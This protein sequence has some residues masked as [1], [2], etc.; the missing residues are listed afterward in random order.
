MPH[1]TSTPTGLLLL[2][3]HGLL[4]QEP[5]IERV[6]RSLF[7]G[8][9]YVV[10]ARRLIGPGALVNRLSL[11]LDVVLVL[12]AAGTGGLDLELTG[13]LALDAVGESLH[14]AD[15]IVLDSVRGMLHPGPV[16]RAQRGPDGYIDVAALFDWARASSGASATPPLPSGLRVARRLL[17]LP[18]VEDP[19]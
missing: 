4:L 13:S 12:C 15:M 3:A 9:H 7:Q 16:L 14:T 17:D 11:A 19:A 18:A 2:E 1:V 6:P 10:R 5:S 8:E